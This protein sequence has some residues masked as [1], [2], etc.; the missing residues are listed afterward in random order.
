MQEA[1]CSPAL[2]AATVGK[3]HTSAAVVVRRPGGAA[4]ARPPRPPPWVNHQ[5]H[6]P[7]LFQSLAFRAGPE[8]QTLKKGRGSFGVADPGRR[9]A[10]PGLFPYRPDG[11]SAGLVLRGLADVPGQAR[12][13][14]GVYHGTKVQQRRCMHHTCSPLK[15]GPSLSLIQFAKL[16]VDSIQSGD[17][18]VETLL[19][20]VE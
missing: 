7:P 10:C 8:S 9:F 16:L 17:H 2:H 18:L 14:Q 13:L 11:T 4:R 12:C 5:H 19:H 6:Q 20:P 1:L 3:G 15:R